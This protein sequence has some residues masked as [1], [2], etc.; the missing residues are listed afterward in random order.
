MLQVPQERLKC[1]HTARSV[2]ELRKVVPLVCDVLLI[3]GRGWDCGHGAQY[4]SW[5]K[6]GRKTILWFGGDCRKLTPDH[7]DG[8]FGSNIGFIR[9]KTV[10]IEEKSVVDTT[11]I[12]AGWSIVYLPLIFFT[13][14][15]GLR[16]YFWNLS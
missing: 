9:L 8:G 7:M 5:Y 6:W 4:K 11:N 16:T 3:G 1:K 15:F 13:P 12:K 2:G 14:A 10:W